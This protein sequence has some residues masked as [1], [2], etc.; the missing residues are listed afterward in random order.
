M[1][2]RTVIIVLGAALA[3]LAF[4][5]LFERDTMTTDERESRADRAFPGFR[6]DFVERLTI[7]GTA[8]EQLELERVAGAEDGGEE[9]RIVKPRALGADGTAVRALLSSLDY[10][11]KERTVRE[12]GALEDPRYG[13]AAPRVKASF[14]IRGQTTAFRIGADT[15]DEKVYLALDD[16]A[17]ELHAVDREVLEALDVT[18]DDLRDKRLVSAAL[19]DARAA[20][21][22]RGGETIGFAREEGGPWRLARGGTRILAAE[23]QVGELLRTVAD[24]EAARF[25]A[26]GVDAAG[27]ARYGLAEPGHR[28]TAELPDD[29]QVELL[30]GAPCP[31]AEHQVHATVAGSGTVACVGDQLLDVLGRPSSRFAELRPAV[32][33]PADVARLVLARGDRSLTLE[34][35]DDDGWILPGEGRP[36]V[37]QA[38]VD[39]LL[40]AL[41]E[42]R[43]TDLAVGAE[44][45]ADLGAPTARI[46]LELD[47]GQAPVELALHALPGAGDAPGE[48]RARRGDE[49]ALLAVDPALLERIDPDELAFRRRVIDTGKAYDVVG[50]RIDGPT[51]QRLAKVDGQ[52]KLVE[53]LEVAADGTA[54]RELAELL[55]EVTVE[56]FAARQATAAHGLARPYAVVAATLVDEQEGAEGVDRAKERT[57]KLEVGAPVGPETADRY[58][59]LADDP[60]VF[61]L[62]GA[63]LDE[64]AQPLV[65]RDLLQVE[66]TAVRK[67]KIERPSGALTA[68]LDG[69]A[70]TA[71]GV[72]GFDGTAFGRLVTDL[73]GVKAIRAA[74][75]GVD[76]APFE[77]PTATVTLWTG[78]GAGDAAPAP[79]TIVF[80]PRTADEAEQGYLARKDGLEVTFVLPARVVEELVAFGQPQP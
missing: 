8:G 23:E 56:R 73:G 6:R 59:R 72:D 62:A 61:V 34:R 28:L 18:L 9:W 67:V 27:L 64:L 70:W 49:A 58:A 50:L 31:D 25:V 79:T 51:K 26:D 39:G 16:G 4:I 69:E 48:L 75:F 29:A 20:T 65:A 54:A 11:I 10:L 2:N 32:F 22:V 47:A 33:R 41:A 46:T 63:K 37:E 38:A 40:T 5:V 52:W 3:L 36:A 17:G 12:P 55:A 57:V 42:A 1:S 76:P 74:R 35:D 80:G 19:S 66:S 78:D 21:L 43:G 7:A 15:K 68:E 53:P 44:V 71:A 13:L 60:V 77:P 14:T 30:V 24:L 45:V